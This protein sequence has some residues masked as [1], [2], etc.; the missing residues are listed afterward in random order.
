MYRFYSSPTNKV[1]VCVV[2][3][4]ETIPN[5]NVLSVAVS[6]CSEKDPFIKKKGRAIAEGRLMKNKTY[7]KVRVPDNQVTSEQ[8]IEIAKIVSEVVIKSKEVVRSE[9]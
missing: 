2:G 7:C 9:D 8:F 5:G 1:R 6:R 4:V 3:K